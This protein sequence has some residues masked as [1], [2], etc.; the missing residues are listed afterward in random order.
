VALVNPS[1]APVFAGLHQM[2]WCVCASTVAG[3][4]TLAT[5]CSIPCQNPT[6]SQVEAFNAKTAMAKETTNNDARTISFV[7]IFFL[8]NPARRVNALNPVATKS[9]TF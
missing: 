4:M 8:V 6:L 9:G 5:L 3:A 2:V 7:F 1:S